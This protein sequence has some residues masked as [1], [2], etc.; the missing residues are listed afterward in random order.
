MKWNYKQAWCCGAALIAACTSF[1]QNNAIF[2][3]GTGDG[4]GIMAY[5]QNTVNIFTGG[6][7]GGWSSQSYKQSTSGIFTGGSGDGW[8]M[9]AYQQNTPSIF[10]GGIGDGW[11]S[12]NY[13]QSTVSIFA[14]GQGDGWSNKGYEQATGN[15]YRGGPGDGWASSYLPQAPLPVTFI[16]FTA[17]KQGNNAALVEWKTGAEANAAWFEVERSADAVSFEFVGK[18]LAAG[19]AAGMRYSFTDNHPLKG[20]NYY[21]LKQV[22]K[23]N[24]LTYTPSR[25]LKFNEAGAGIVKY[26]PNPTSGILNIEISSQMRSETM[27]INISNAS[28]SVLNQIKVGVGA[29]SVLQVPLS[30]YPKGIYF[31]QV[32]TPT[33][34]STQR[35]VLQ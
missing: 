21:R 3:G 30:R 33:V 32:K 14:G 15:I 18:V 4:Y 34:N 10:V 23:D 11:A 9:A 35:V 31:I 6:A 28:G 19:S 16:Y 29:L 13:V 2:K 24:K 22:D 5:T 20:I 25:L 17:Q 7:G 26:Y 1:G 27:I 8:G 12:N